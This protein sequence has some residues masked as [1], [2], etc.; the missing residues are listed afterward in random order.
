MVTAIIRVITTIAANAVGAG[1]LG[2]G[3]GAAAYNHNNGYYHNNGNNYVYINHGVPY[4]GGYYHGGYY[5]GSG[6]HGTGP[7]IRPHLSGGFHR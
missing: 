1:L 7:V 5:H 4:H 6:F 3:L 2:F